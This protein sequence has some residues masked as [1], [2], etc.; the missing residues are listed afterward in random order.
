MDYTNW[1]Y[2]IVHKIELDFAECYYWHSVHLFSCRTGICEAI[3]AKK[4]MSE[5][6]SNLFY[7]KFILE[8]YYL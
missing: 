7:S 1:C 5:P 8:S 2:K 3:F 6:T 4:I